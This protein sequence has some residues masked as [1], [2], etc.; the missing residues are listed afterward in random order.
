MHLRFVWETSGACGSCRGGP[1]D[2]LVATRL[3]SPC[4]RRLNVRRRAIR[5]PWRA[6]SRLL[7]SRSHAWGGICV[8]SCRCFCRASI[9][10]LALCIFRSWRYSVSGLFLL[11][12]CLSCIRAPLNVSA[13][14]CFRSANRCCVLISSYYHP[15][16]LLF[17]IISLRMSLFFTNIITARLTV[18]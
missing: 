2:K 8:Q 3:V 14:L 6:A 18:C 11:K 13:M 5:S 9:W 10:V 17:M 1:A 4:A 16:S 7:A 12:F 15:A